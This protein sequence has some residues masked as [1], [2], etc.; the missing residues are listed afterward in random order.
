M[1]YPAAGRAGGLIRL[2]IFRIVM[3]PITGIPLFAVGSNTP[4]FRAVR[5]GNTNKK[6][7]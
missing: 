2:W 3:S 4:P 7:Q 5:I 6:W 1:N